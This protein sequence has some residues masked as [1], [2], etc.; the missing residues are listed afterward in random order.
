MST[1]RDNVTVTAIG[2]VDGS[3]RVKVRRRGRRTDRVEV[4]QI[5]AAVLRAALRAADG[6]P[7]RLDWSGAAVRDGVITMIR[8]LN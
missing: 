8:V 3:R 1:V 2:P 5:H 6:D 4:Y 7:R